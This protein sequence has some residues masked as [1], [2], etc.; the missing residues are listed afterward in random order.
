M[1]PLSARAA[2]FQDGLNCMGFV[3]LDLLSIRWAQVNEVRGR[4]TRELGIDG[5]RILFAAT[6][7]H[8]GPAVANL[9]DVRRD[10]AYCAE[11]SEKLVQLVARAQSQQEEA[12][13]AFVHKPVW[14]LS[15]NRR[16]IMRNGLV[17]THGPFHSADALCVEGPID[18]ELAIV[19]VCSKSGKPLGILANFACHPIHHGGEPV[20][21]AGYPGAFA[22]AMKE[23]D[24]PITLFLNGACGNLS[25]GI[26]QQNRAIGREEFGQIL[27]RETADLLADAD[28]D[29]TVQVGACSR[30]LQLPYRSVS[31]EEIAGKIRGAQRFIDPA[32]YDRTIP[33]LLK[34]MQQRSHI[35]AEVQVLRLGPWYYAAIPGEYF[36]EHG[37]RIKKES[38]P[39]I[40]LVIS[41]A[42]GMLG[43][44]PTCDAFKRGGYETT[45]APSSKMAA[46]T[47]DLLADAAIEQI[48]QLNE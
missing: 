25:S 22:S 20:F 37:L 47:G 12:K 2:L 17:K 7:N 11:L 38:L 46:E 34:K 36:V 31:D 28:Y 3:Q 26:P 13:L 19:G 5:T 16:L 27:A 45:F 39:Q 30:T 32:I 35:P 40:A 9:G 41:C 42:N 14:T 10:T 21:S 43:Y 4:I 18:P 48:K 29:R 6:H 24:W 1:N 44:L 33:A 8:C 15:H 23:K